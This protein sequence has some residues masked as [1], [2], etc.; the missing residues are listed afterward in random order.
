MFRQF[1]ASLRLR[2]L[3]PYPLVGDNSQRDKGS[4]VVNLRG[5]WKPGAVQIYAELL[6]VLASRDK[7]IAYYYEYYVPAAMPAPAQGR[8]SR[9]VEP[10]TLRIGM[11]YSF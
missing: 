4:T 2:H 9:V 11:K 8:V 7:D 3:G 1:E 10:R 5:A 6:N